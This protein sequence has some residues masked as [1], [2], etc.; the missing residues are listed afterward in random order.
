M[1]SGH[2]GSAPQRRSSD[3]DATKRK[4]ILRALLL[5]ILAAVLLALTGCE[6]V[7]AP[8]ASRACVVAKPVVSATETASGDVLL[9]PEDAA[10]LL[11]YIQALEAC[12]GD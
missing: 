1:V 4:Q 5:A 7:P 10:E 12:I 9:S 2:Y 3:V 11:I 8:S 6:L